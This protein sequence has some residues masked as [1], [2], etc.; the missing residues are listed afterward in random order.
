MIFAKGAR[1]A[2]L[3]P[4]Y[5]AQESHFAG[6]FPPASHRE[7][8]AGFNLL[9]FFCRNDLAFS[10]VDRQIG[11]P[12]VIFTIRTPLVKT[13][14]GSVIFFS[15]II[16]PQNCFPWFCAKNQFYT[17]RFFRVKNCFPC[18]VL[19]TKEFGEWFYRCLKGA[20]TSGVYEESKKDIGF[21]HWRPTEEDIQCRWSQI[22]FADE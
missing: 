8:A 12:V 18:S 3:R 21:R 6:A 17:S 16:K 14:Q 10:S 4:N 1:D 13:S 15:K 11:K 2:V 19:A 5:F 20:F 22:F 7:N 9:D